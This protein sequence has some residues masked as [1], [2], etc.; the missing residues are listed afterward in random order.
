MFKELLE[1]LYGVKKIRLTLF[2]V[3]TV[4]FILSF[5]FYF[6]GMIS[7]IAYA[8]TIF[9]YVVNNVA[10]LTYDVWFDKKPTKL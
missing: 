9:L 8:S 7:Y 3:L 2:F 10:M 6:L 4:L 1:K 5:L